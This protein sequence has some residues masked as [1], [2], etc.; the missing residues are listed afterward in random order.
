MQGG[1]GV[2][3]GGGAATGSQQPK[4][5]RVTMKDKFLKSQAGTN[6]A[7]VWMVTR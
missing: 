5:K 6:P 1:V 2:V 7:E 3:A 4:I